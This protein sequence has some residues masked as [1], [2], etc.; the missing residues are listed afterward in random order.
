MIAIRDNLTDLGYLCVSTYFF[1][2]KLPINFV[3]SFR[4]FYICAMI[5][6]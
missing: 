2:K 1:K 5:K 3:K 6:K 4:V